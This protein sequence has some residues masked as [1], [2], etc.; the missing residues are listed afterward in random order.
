L[1]SIQP[2]TEILVAFIVSTSQV[3][4]KEHVYFPAF[5]C[6]LSELTSSVV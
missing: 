4:E 6:S 5:H 2:H 3:L 1:S